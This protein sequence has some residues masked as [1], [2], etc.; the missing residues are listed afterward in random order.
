MKGCCKRRSSRAM[1][2][3]RK[4]AI[5][6]QAAKYDRVCG[7]GKEEIQRKAL[8]NDMRDFIFYSPCASGRYM[9]LL[10]VLF[11]NYCINDCLYCYNRRSNDI[12][13]AAFE[14]QELAHATY[15]LYRKNYIEGLF[16]SSG[17]FKNS[18]YTMELM[19]LTVQIL[20]KVYGFKGY[21][22][23]KIIPGASFDLV[24]KAIR[25]ADRVSCNIELP[26]EGSLRLLAPEKSKNDILGA[27]RSAR[28]YTLELEKHISASTQL[29]IGATP[30]TDKTILQLSHELYANKLV[31]R[32]YYS[33]YIPVNSNDIM[34]QIEQPPL[35]REHRL[36]QADWLM[37]FYGFKAEDI[38]EGSEDLSQDM[39][40]KM[41]W[42][43]RNMHLFPVDIKKAPYEKLIL[44]PGI[45]P[46]TAKKIIKA[47]REG[48]LDEQGLKVLGTSLKR[49]RNFI[50]IGGKPLPKEPPSQKRPK[51][52]PRPSSKQLVLF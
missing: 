29:I 30:E 38:F 8:H 6:A 47:R 19:I 13:R 50:T 27:L 4:L 46:K 45:G 51:K 37:R 49:A 14:P 18:D 32:V 44:V 12:E 2:I 1:K 41:C 20:R 9:P 33:A 36:Y 11:T 17:I 15:E 40:P 43:L 35:S 26:T 5:L 23:L 10:K 28:N 31:K 16:L 39:D 22:H 21:I 3:E 42:A 24:K 7:K 34:P 25:F 52:A 48:Y